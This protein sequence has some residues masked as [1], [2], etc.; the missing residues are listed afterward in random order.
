MKQSFINA[1][2]PEEAVL[3]FKNIRHFDKSP[4]AIWFKTERN[5]YYVTTETLSQNKTI[6]NFNKI[7]NTC[8]LNAESRLKYNS[9][10]E[11]YDQGVLAGFERPPADTN[12]GKLRKV[13]EWLL[14][15]QHFVL[16]TNLG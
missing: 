14:N 12:K 10:L 2:T 7:K 1:Q 6:I 16:F 5:E 3:S 9:I 11:K 8:I 4:L 15:N 13:Y